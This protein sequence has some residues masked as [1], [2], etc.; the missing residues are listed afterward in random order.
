M[1]KAQIAQAMRAIINLPAVSVSNKG[2]FKTIFA[3]Y[4][5]E[6]IPFPDAYQIVQ[7]MAARGSQIYSF[8]D[9][10]DDISGINRIEP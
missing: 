6:N 1:P 3:L 4:T 9:D 7:M 8:D 5:N 10:F 2:R